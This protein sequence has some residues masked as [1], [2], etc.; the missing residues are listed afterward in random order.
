GGKDFIIAG[1]G[2]DE[3]VDT[4]ADRF[5]PEDDGSDIYIGDNLTKTMW[6]QFKDFLLGLVG[7]DDEDIVRYSVENPTTG[8]LGELGV[9]ILGGEIV[10]FA[11]KE[12]L[13]LTVRDLN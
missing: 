13:K 5:G 9:E 3:I 11:D 7:A 4:I 8:A 6:Q 10:T 12:A 2:D 1:R